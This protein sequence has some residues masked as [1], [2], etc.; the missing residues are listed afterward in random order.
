MRGLLPLLLL[1]TTGV[2]SWPSSKK[3]KKDQS[4][5]EQLI[6]WVLA[7]GGKLVRGGALRALF[8]I[9]VPRETLESAPTMRDPRPR[10]P[11]R[12]RARLPPARLPAPRAEWL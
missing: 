10:F 3:N 11:A 6:D 2:S 7:K 4:I 5:E 12:R 8:V 1:L 9:R